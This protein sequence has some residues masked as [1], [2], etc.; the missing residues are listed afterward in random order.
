METIEVNL[1]DYSIVQCR[2]K[3]NQNTEWHDTIIKL[4]KDNMYKIKEIA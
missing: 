1:K 3:Y 4:L 2:G